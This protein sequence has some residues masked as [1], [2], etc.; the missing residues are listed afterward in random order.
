MT[1]SFFWRTLCFSFPAV[2]TEH[3]TLGT[4]VLFFL[5]RRPFPVRKQPEGSCEDALKGRHGKIL[6]E[7]ELAFAK[8]GREVDKNGGTPKRR[9]GWRLHMGTMDFFFSVLLVCTT[10]TTTTKRRRET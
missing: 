4:A 2:S 9:R 6:P 3:T 1:I 10:T 7:L 5:F 8:E